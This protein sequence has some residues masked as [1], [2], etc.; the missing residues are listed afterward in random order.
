MPFF[1]DNKP[2]V[3]LKEKQNG[4]RGRGG[5]PPRS[6]ASSAGTGDLDG[7]VGVANWRPHP[8]NRLGAPSRSSQSIRGLRP[9]IGNL[10]PSIEVASVLHGYQQPRWRGRGGQLAALAREL[11]GNA[12]SE[13]P[14]DW[15]VGASYRR[16]RPLQHGCQRPPWVL[17]TSVERSRSPIGD[18][19][20]QSLG[21]SESEFPID[22]RAGVANRRPRPL[23]C[24]RQYPRRTLILV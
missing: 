20:P 16:P 7:G 18:P 17:A 19:S 15:G 14:V 5:L 10:D 1:R 24:G 2:P 13:S 22:S 8:P 11:I 21:D 23:H 3:S 12:D 4:R 9:S 6:P